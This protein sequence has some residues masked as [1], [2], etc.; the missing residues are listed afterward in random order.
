[1]GNSVDGAAPPPDPEDKRLRGAAEESLNGPPNRGVFLE[2]LRREVERAR[3]ERTCLGILLIDLDDLKAINEN[4]GRHVGDAAL[5]ETGARVRS[6]LR[7]TDIAA[8]IDG[9]KFAVLLTDIGDPWRAETCADRVIR[10]IRAPFLFEG[11]M[12]LLETSF[13]LALFPDDGREADPLMDV[14]DRAMR[15]AMRKR[16]AGGSLNEGERSSTS[17]VDGRS[18]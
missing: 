16:K 12:V 5:R 8:R 15:E 18:S 1:M 2:R 14:A 7:G 10:T 9:D 13:G 11:R 17:R 3:T 6:T 4:L